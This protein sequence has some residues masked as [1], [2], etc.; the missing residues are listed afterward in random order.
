MKLASLILLFVASVTHSQQLIK[1][2][3]DSARYVTYSTDNKTGL[4][5]SYYWSVDNGPYVYNG[6]SYGI[7]WSV[8]NAGE[9]VITVYFESDASCPSEPVSLNITVE[10]CELTVMWAPN[11][12]TPN[13][14]ANN[15]TWSPKGENYHDAYVYVVNRW[16]EV[17]FESYN[18][19]IGWDGTYNG[20]PCN[21]GVYIYMLKWNDSANKLHQQTGQISLI[22]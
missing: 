22:R 1:L 19:N 18:M 10:V 2:C 4:P 11:V 21:E 16:G 15:N 14:D 5:G 17:M 12:F 6:A 20:V 7:T 3:D 13:G 9:H 8:E